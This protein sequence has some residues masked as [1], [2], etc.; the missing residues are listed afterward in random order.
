MKG[1]RGRAEWDTVWM[2]HQEEP[3]YIIGVDTGLPASRC[4]RDGFKGRL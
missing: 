2:I 3:D 1:G 4:D